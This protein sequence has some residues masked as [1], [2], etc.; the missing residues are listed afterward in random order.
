[1]VIGNIEQDNLCKSPNLFFFGGCGLELTSE[2]F[3]SEGRGEAWVVDLVLSAR[4]K[5]PR[6]RALSDASCARGTPVDDTRVRV[7]AQKSKALYLFFF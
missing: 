7:D 6:T 2:W 5:V 3:V 1:M 4:L